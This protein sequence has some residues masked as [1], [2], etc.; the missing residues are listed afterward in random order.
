M[1]AQEVAAD[2]SEEFYL[3]TETCLSAIVH[4]LAGEV[5]GKVRSLRSAACPSHFQSQPGLRELTVGCV[6][7]NDC[8]LIL[9]FQ[10]SALDEEM[11]Q[12]IALAKD[13]TW[14]PGPYPGVS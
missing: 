1:S 13:K 2:L 7:S 10:G 6:Q 12:Y 3:E 11:F 4:A 5:N 14:Q 8:G 9:H